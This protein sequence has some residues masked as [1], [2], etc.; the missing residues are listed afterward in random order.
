MTFLTLGCLT[1]VALIG[2]STVFKE[3]WVPDGW[4][5]TRIQRISAVG[6]RRNSGYA[7]STV[8]SLDLLGGVASRSV[9]IDQA[10]YTPQF[11]QLW[12]NL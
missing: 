8:P 2:F 12:L 4:S 1:S 5:P 3:G 6:Q 10:L 7:G 11:W 9:H